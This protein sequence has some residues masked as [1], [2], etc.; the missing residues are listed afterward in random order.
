MTN[1]PEWV[2]TFRRKWEGANTGG[3]N[4]ISTPVMD[5]MLSDI[6]DILKE[7]N[8]EKAL[9][10]AAE[11]LNDECLAEKEES[12][13]EG[14]MAGG[15]NAFPICIEEIEKA[16]AELLSKIEEE[17][18]RIFKALTV[19]ID[20]SQMLDGWEKYWVSVGS[21]RYIEGCIE[22]E[23]SKRIKEALLSKYKTL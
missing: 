2:E 14:Q 8:F 9:A 18:E 17:K 1:E 15:L 5:E 19:D 3:H 12:Y 16:K 4:A 21:G 20:T 11:K 13:L 7:E 22:C 23:N 10:K 6:Q